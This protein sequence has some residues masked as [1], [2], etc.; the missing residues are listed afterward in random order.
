LVKI[1]D[2]LESGADK[3][4]VQEAKSGKGMQ[5]D[6]AAKVYIET[7]IDKIG[8]ENKPKS[9]KKQPVEK[10]TKAVKAAGNATNNK[11]KDATA[12]ATAVKKEAKKKS[13]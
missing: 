10:E 13:T 1:T 2:I 8:A 3:T 9:V 4:N 7:K 6:Y 5:I 11:K 12:N